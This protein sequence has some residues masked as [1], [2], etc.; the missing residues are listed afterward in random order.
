MTEQQQQQQ[1]CQ[2]FSHPDLEA[3]LEDAGATGTCQAFECAARGTTLRGT[4][5]VG[6]VPRA[7]TLVAPTTGPSVLTL[8]AA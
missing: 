3:Y 7:F 4:L 2:P 8:R 6:G 5:T 1:R